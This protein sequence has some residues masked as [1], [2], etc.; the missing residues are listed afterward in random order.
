[1]SAPTA[2]ASHGGV[3]PGR[4][5]EQDSR[6]LGPLRR[7]VREAGLGLI[8]AGFIVL[9]FVAYQLW[10]TGISE[11]NSQSALAKHFDAAVHAARAAGTGKG[12]AGTGGT[13]GTGGRG[14]TGATG[15]GAPTTAASPTAGG[16][17][18]GALPGTPGGGAIDHL[19]IPSIGV[20]KFVVQGTDEADLR[21]GPGHYPQTVMPGEKGNAAIAGH[22]T[23][24]GAPFF[25]L[26]ELHAGDAIY[27]TN[28]GGRTFLYRVSR[29]PRAV[30]PDDVAVLDNTSFPELTLTTCNPRFSAAQRLIVV[31]RLVGTALP[32]P[33]PVTPGSGSTSASGGAPAT[34]SSGTGGGTGSG[35]GSTQVGAASLGSGNSGAWPAA[36]GYGALFVV[37][38][39][40]VRILINR[41]RRWTRLG[42]YVGGIALCLVPLWFCF[43]NVVLLLPQSI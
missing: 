5:A 32:A 41:T 20:D 40:A 22:R 35:S 14:G 27:I 6:S 30:N 17:S 4:A 26:N 33:R 1:M 7:G 42:V 38:W 10:G 25:R 23:T 39:I 2:Q 37:L 15:I 12:T 24:Y 18:A 3:N 36:L 9:L 16:G 28:L 13:G 11:A 8:T 29:P 43:E 19:V 31:A 34:P 21:R